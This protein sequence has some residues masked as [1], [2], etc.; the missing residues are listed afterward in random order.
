MIH[1]IKIT[2]RRRSTTVRGWHKRRLQGMIKTV[3]QCLAFTD[4]F[5]FSQCGYD[6][7]IDTNID[8]N[9]ISH[10]NIYSLKVTLD[11][12]DEQLENFMKYLKNV[13]GWYT[14]T[15][16]SAPKYGTIST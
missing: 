8:T 14:I 2:M 7:K 3:I 5:E 4:P 10:V 6:F 15:L 1:D 11:L 9:S 16:L 12:T 13:Q